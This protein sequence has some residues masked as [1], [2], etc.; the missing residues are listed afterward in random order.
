MRALADSPPLDLVVFGHSHV[1]AL[2][3]APGGGV[4]ANAGSWLDA[5]TFLKLTPQRIELRSFDGSA[6]GVR[7]DSIDRRP[8]KALGHP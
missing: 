2:E 6:E 5:P 7:L 3:R 1:P 4:Y 8:E